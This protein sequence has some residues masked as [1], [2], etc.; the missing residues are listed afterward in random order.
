M[1]MSYCRFSNTTSDLCDCQENMG[2]NEIENYYD[3]IDE[4]SIS[5]SER[6]CRFE[7]IRMCIDIALEYGSEVDR[8]VKQIELSQ[9]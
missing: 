4:N 7:L 2:K 1:N 6:E 9:E 5:D 8:P 3:E